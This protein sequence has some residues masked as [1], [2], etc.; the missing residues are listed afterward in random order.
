MLVVGYFSLCMFNDSS[1][2]EFSTSDSQTSTSLPGDVLTYDSVQDEN[3][4]FVL[5]LY[6][7][8]AVLCLVLMIAVV[9][10]IVLIFII[11]PRRRGGQCCT[12]CYLI[13]NILCLVLGFLI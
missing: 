4:D 3:M 9:V 10:I 8:I 13:F 7:I 6:I 12:M 1:S 2:S 5:W 11:K